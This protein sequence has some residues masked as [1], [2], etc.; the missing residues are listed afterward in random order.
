[1]ATHPAKALT[2]YPQTGPARSYVRD[3]WNGEPV[4]RLAQPT[5]GSGVPTEPW[6][7]SPPLSA[8]QL[9]EQLAAE[10]E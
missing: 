3:E 8:R 5:F 7:E 9:A 10:L 6:P 1:M 4:W 2:V